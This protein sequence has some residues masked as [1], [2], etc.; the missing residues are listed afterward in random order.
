M[1]RALSGSTSS[2]K[3]SLAKFLQTLSENDCLS[4]SLSAAGSQGLRNGGTLDIHPRRK[5]LHPKSTTQ[6]RLG[7]FIIHAPDRF[8]L[9]RVAFD[10]G[11]AIGVRISGC[12][13]TKV[14]GHSCLCS[15]VPAPL[16]K[17]TRPGRGRPAAYIYL[18]NPQT[19]D[20]LLSTS[21]HDDDS[22]TPHSGCI[23][24]PCSVAYCVCAHT[25]QFCFLFPGL[26][27]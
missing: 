21:R 5:T 22:Q 12:F 24:T 16:S 8:H 27:R 9:G 18:A 20:E 6:A 2:S 19:S 4:E 7:R 25:S 10:G 14:E 26:V 17:P 11:S 13:L 15:L 1:L 3:S 23:G